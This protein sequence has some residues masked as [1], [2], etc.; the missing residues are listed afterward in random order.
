LV[1]GDEQLLDLREYKRIKIIKVTECLKL[2][3]SW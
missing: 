3:W 2:L 1:T